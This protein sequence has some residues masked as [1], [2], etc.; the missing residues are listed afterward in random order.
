MY[1][2]A[3]QEFAKAISIS[4]DQIKNLEHGSAEYYQLLRRDADLHRLLALGWQ[5][6]GRFKL[7]LQEIQ[8][9]I[10]MAMMCN[11]LQLQASIFTD[12]SQILQKEGVYERA[13]EYLVKAVKIYENW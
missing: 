12:M 5:N 2:S 1:D 10:T 11:D 3:V 7:A 4:D 6:M 9:G 13:L 8:R